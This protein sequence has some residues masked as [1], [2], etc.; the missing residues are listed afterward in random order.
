MLVK[1]R[2][3]AVLILG[4]LLVGCTVTPT[5]VLDDELNQRASLDLETMFAA[6]AP[7]S[8]PIDLYEAIARA[9]KYNLEYRVQVMAEG[10]SQRQLDTSRY[11]LLPQLAANAGYSHRDNV[12]ASNSFSISRNVES[13]ETSTSQEQELFN[14]Q[15]QVVWNVLDFGVSYLRQQQTADQ[16][17]IATERR[18]KVVQNIIQ[19][20]RAA[21]W[22]VVAAD[23]VV[24]QLSQMVAQID[25]ALQT[26]KQ[27]Q[28][29]GIRSPLATLKFRRDLLKT[30]RVMVKRQDDLR[31]ARLELARLM[32]LAPGQD[33]QV[34]IADE[35]PL[36]LAASAVGLQ[37][38][39]FA[40]L[41]QR[42]E[43]LELDYSARIADK[44]A[45]ITNLSFLPGISFRVGSNYDDNSFLLNQNWFDTGVQVSFNLMR[46]ASL[47]SSRALQAQQI[48]L[49]DAQRQALTAAV[50]TQVNVALQ[51]YAIAQRDYALSQRAAEIESQ[52]TQ[53][54]TA[55]RQSGTGQQLE[56][57]QSQA[58][59]L[60]AMMDQHFQ[61][62]QLQGS[63]GLV[64][65]SLG[66]DPLPVT[67]GS[68]DIATLSQ[69]IQ[70]YFEQSLPALIE[71]TVAQ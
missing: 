10:V 66:I 14:A 23:R 17:L 63:Y 30:Y 42:P 37:Q 34:V 31:L 3:G 4:L 59:T 64:L 50:L 6:Q 67:V 25:Q 53:Q 35:Q 36:A 58:D 39:Q 26:A 46:L 70:Q 8:Q 5:P 68:H 40:A 57:I 69:E 61:Y 24:S 44:E 28:T 33:Y 13:L 21:Y 9:L 18:R 47:P 43:L 48:A 54:F 1:M 32:N 27:L 19:D 29:E 65:N 56:L 49:L 2:F 15:A 55:Q 52:R 22:R 38:L 62:V 60:L 12:N 45:M 51:S 11:D 20:V 7:I 71:Q 16:T 41:T